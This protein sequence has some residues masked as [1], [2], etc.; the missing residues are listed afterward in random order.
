MND[1]STY[2]AKLEEEKTRLEAELATV[3]RQNPANPADWEPTAADEAEA[4]PN[5]E[6][7]HM[8]R[9]G[10]NVAIT[11]DLEARYKDVQDALARIENGTYGTCEV[12]G[13]EI[14]TDRLEADPAARTCKAHMN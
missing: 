1:T 8:E 5:L 9:F 13:E 3:S 14:E 4:D 10:E 6:A 11:E 7:D 2:K 12:S